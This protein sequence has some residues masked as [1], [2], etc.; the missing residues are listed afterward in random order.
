MLRK[1]EKENAAVWLSDEKQEAQALSR[2][3]KC[4]VFVLTEE[5]RGDFAAGVSWC[6][7]ADAGWKTEKA[8]ALEERFGE[9][10][11]LRVWQRHA[12]LPWKILE[13]QRFVLRE[14][15]EEDLDVLYEIQGKEEAAFLE[16]LCEDKEE[17]RI[18]IQEYIRHMYGFY[19]FGIWM[20]QEKESGQVIGRAG[21]QMREGFEEPEI[22]FALAPAFR[23]QG[24]AQEACRGVLEYAGRE[25]GLEQIRA[26]VHR[27][28]EK[29]RRL[30]GKLGFQVDE[31]REN[32][33]G[34]WIFYRY[35]RVADAF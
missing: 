9:E 2:E 10:W 32:R 34:M 31:S 21:L 12:G 20:I 35:V 27:E 6:A 3:G 17:Q 11:L 4:V 14:M 30:C 19:G 24:A 29:S 28:N 7:E 18:K 15:T 8:G 5:N 26:V 16:P 13:T 25:L 1:W 22:G 23:G 33:D